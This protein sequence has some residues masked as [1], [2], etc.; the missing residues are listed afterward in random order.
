M[1]RSLQG[2]ICVVSMLLFTG[3]TTSRYETR[4]LQT[5][6]SRPHTEEKVAVFYKPLSKKESLEYLGRNW[7]GKGFQPVQI[8]VENYSPDPI[9]FF[10]KGICLP[11]VNLEDIKQRAHSATEAKVLAVAA[12][13]LTCVGASMFGLILAPATFGVSGVLVPLAVGGFGIHTASKWARSDLALDQD[14]E[15]K[16]LHDKEIPGNGVLEGIIFVP[17][18]AFIEKFRVKIVDP[19]QEKALLVQAKRFRG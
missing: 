5:I 14:Y 13:S 2:F 7:I 16:F 19:K 17:K 3:C 4:P 15:H 12:P 8:V 1:K 18:D 10:R 11:T 6:R 9:R